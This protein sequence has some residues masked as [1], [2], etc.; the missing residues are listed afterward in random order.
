[1]TRAK[2]AV[3]AYGERVALLY[4]LDQ[5][6]SLLERNWR[7]RAGEIDIIMADGDAVVFCEVKTRRSEAFGLP[8]EALVPAKVSRMRRLAAQWLSEHGNGPVRARFDV[9][10]IR[11]QPAGAAKVEHLR[12]A[13]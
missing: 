9:L 4:L 1:M 10:S 13:F 11:P 3:G 5:G 6:M 2:D 8:V 12:G 7:G